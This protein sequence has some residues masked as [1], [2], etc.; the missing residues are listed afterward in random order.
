[1]DYIP[2]FIVTITLLVVFFVVIIMVQ[3]GRYLRDTDK[4]IELHYERAI[5]MQELHAAERKDLIDRLMARDLTEVK[6]AQA[7]RQG[8]GKVMSKRINDAKIAEEK[9]KLEEG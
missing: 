3:Q 7:I 9:K 6:Q 1:M 4:L 5:A 8:S 2:L